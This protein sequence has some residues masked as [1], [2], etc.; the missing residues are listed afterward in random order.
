MGCVLPD[1]ILIGVIF[2]FFTWQLK[3]KFWLS[4]KLFIFYLPG[5]ALMPS[6]ALI[7]KYESAV[8]AHLITNPLSH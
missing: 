3:S 4:D 1:P 2:F 7:K 8:S 6:H 5:Q